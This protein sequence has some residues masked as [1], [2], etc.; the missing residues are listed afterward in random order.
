MVQLEGIGFEVIGGLERCECR[1][2]AAA[3]RRC[4]HGYGRGRVIAVGREMLAKA[5]TLRR[6]HARQAPD[7]R[8]GHI[9]QPR[10]MQDA[11]DE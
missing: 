10:V 1:V 3:A 4:E 7:E 11:R 8:R 9:G 2:V 6:D 5:D